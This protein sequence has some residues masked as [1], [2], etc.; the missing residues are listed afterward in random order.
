MRKSNPTANEELRNDL[1]QV[2]DNPENVAEVDWS[3]VRDMVFNEDRV[4]RKDAITRIGKAHCL[5]CPEFL[6]H[7]TSPELPLIAVH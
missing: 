7:V 3:K 1:I 5:N 6:E 4:R 2:Y